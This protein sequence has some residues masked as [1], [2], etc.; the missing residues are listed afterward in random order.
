MIRVFITTVQ[1]SPIARGLFE[2]GFAHARCCMAGTIGLKE[3]RRWQ[4]GKD[5]IIF[6]KGIYDSTRA[7]PITLP[8]RDILLP[9]FNL[10]DENRCR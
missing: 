5:A 2:K 3:T 4:M 9:A 8:S 7:V 6:I 10:E 1:G